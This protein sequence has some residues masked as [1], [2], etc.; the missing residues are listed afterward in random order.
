MQLILTAT[1]FIIP[2]ENILCT[3]SVTAFGFAT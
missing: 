2:P 3:I 1:I